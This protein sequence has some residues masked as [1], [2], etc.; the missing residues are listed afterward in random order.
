MRRFFLFSCLFAFGCG[1]PAKDD[2]T[3]PGGDTG[4]SDVDTTILGPD[5][6]VMNDSDAGLSVEVIGGSAASWHFGAIEPRVDLYEEGCREASEVCHTLDANGGLL[7]W[8]SDCGSNSDGSTCIAQLYWRQ[9][10]MS[11]MIK[12]ATGLGCWAWGNDAADLYP[13]CTIT[14]W[15][16]DSY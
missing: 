15:E 4:D 5:D 16:P 11:F 13:G 14:N 12:P 1:D 3:S 6:V 7:S 10:E 2:T 9:G 8:A